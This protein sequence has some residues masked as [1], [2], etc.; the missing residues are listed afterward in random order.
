MDLDNWLSNIYH[1]IL[2]NCVKVIDDNKNFKLS[3]SCLVIGWVHVESAM[4]GFRMQ[5]KTFS[6][7]A[8]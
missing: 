3:F 1:V 6:G 8:Y 5:N 7:V 4:I 2:V